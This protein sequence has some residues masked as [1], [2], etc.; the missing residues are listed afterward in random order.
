MRHPTTGIDPDVDQFALY[1]IEN[2]SA[3]VFLSDR[4]KW[5]TLDGRPWN[6]TPGLAYFK[7]VEGPD[8][9]TVGW[10]HRA[11]GRGD[12]SSLLPQPWDTSLPLGTFTTTWT[13]ELLP[14]QDQIDV[15]TQTYE[16]CLKVIYPTSRTTEEAILSNSA[17]LDLAENGTV[18]AADETRL[19]AIRAAKALLTK[20]QVRRDVLLAAIEVGAV[21]SLQL[22]TPQ[23]GGWPVPWADIESAIF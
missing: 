11:V 4:V 23:P 14:K 8:Q 17:V 6:P 13:T 2:P 12:I 1:N 10:Q 15:V 22:S 18:D 16:R 9:P 5:P 20:A 3:L 21:E 19:Q 7:M